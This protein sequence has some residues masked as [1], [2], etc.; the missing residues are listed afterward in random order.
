MLSSRDSHIIELW[1]QRQASPHTRGCYRRDAARL[2]A[3]VPKPLNRLT[4]GDLQSFAQSLVE[5]GL[6]PI[7]RVR[8][9]AA[10]KSLFGFCQ[11]M[12]YVSGNPAA[13][14]ALPCYEKRLAERIVGEDDVRR[15]VETDA[16]PRN[17]A[18]L[19]L[20]YGAG[21]RVSEACGLLWRNVRPRGDS[22]QITVFGKNGRT[23]SIALTAPLWAE[24]TALREN[25]GAEEPVFPSRTGRLLDRGRVRVIVRRAAKRAGIADAVSPHWLR[26]AHA[27]HALDHGAPI[28]LVQA[29]LGHSSVATTSSYLHARPG[30][31][32][33]RFLALERFSPEPSRIRLPLSPAGV[34]NVTTAK[35][36]RTKEKPI[37]ATFTIDSD[38]NITAHAVLPASTDES[39]SFSN[40]KDLAKLTAEWPASRLVDTWNSFAGVAPFDDLKPVKKFTD[41]KA[42]VGRIWQAVARLSP[43]AAQPAPDVAPAKGNGKKSPSKA[44]RPAR[45][46][47]GESESRSNKKAEVI[48]MMKRA[49]GVTLAEIVEVT[50]WQKH[51]VRGFVSILG[52]KGGQKI[53]SS[54]N[55][56]GDRTY[57]IAK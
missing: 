45:A 28:H 17:R 35:Y 54:K 13:E 30:D 37:M 2:L 49:K 53:E 43:D 24:L 44:S 55:T 50:G 46:Q 20:L 42:A 14:L 40:P 38:N 16:K 5:D 36:K 15:L 10:I 23:R 57:H 34:M 31:S 56:A 18:L 4:L 25:A 19:R 6:A 39:Q 26:H 9:L 12:R 48:A 47:K 41:R 32:S 51:T 11:R 3:Q 29:T 7:S 22:G 27:S 8:T 33:A 1:L 21:M 52:S